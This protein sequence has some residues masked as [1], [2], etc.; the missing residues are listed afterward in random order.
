MFIQF[1]SVLLRKENRIN[2]P[3]QKFSYCNFKPIFFSVF[4]NNLIP[5][6]RNNIIIKLIIFS[7][8]IELI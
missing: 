7:N 3:K 2:K 4:G 5:F 6:E 8:R 1:N